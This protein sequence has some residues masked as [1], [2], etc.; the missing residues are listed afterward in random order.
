MSDEAAIPIELRSIHVHPIKSCAGV[1][2]DEALLVE[3]G[4][5]FDRAWMLVDAD[6]EFVSQRELPRMALVTPTLRHADLLL[7]APGMLALHLALDAVEEPTRVRVWNDEVAAY[8]M[9]ALAA[10]WFSDFLRQPLRLVRFDP[11]QKRLSAKSWTGPI[12]A[13]NA[14]SDAFPILVASTASL[15][16]LN[17]RLGARGH[18]PVGMD[19]FRPNLVIASGEF[20]AHGEDHVDELVFDTAEGPVRLKLVKPCARCPIPDVDPA[21]GV[22]D[23]PRTVSETLAG[24]RADARLGGAVTFG[25]NAVIVEGVERALRVGQTGRATLAF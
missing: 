14:F 9:G 8:D 25:M 15:D 12:D 22:F 2:V 24:Y 19:R 23:T 11:E 3:T 21:T 7:R 10:Q 20:D 5:E 16:A 18:G 4:L 6:G 17:A 1:S 13:E